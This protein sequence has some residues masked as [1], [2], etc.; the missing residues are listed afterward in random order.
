MKKVSIVKVVRLNSG[1][2]RSGGHHRPMTSNRRRRH[3]PLRR[4][5]GDVTKLYAQPYADAHGFYCSS[6]EEF[7]AG[8]AKL[9]RRHVEEV[10]IQFID[11]PDSLAQLFGALDIGQADVHK[12]FDEIEHYDLET[13]AKLYGLVQYHGG[14]SYL[15]SAD[16]DDIRMFEGRPEDWAYSLI[17]DTGFPRERVGGTSWSPKLAPMWSY[18]DFDQ[19]WRGL[20]TEL[21]EQTI[22]EVDHLHDAQEKVEYLWNEGLISEPSSDEELLPYFDAELFARD[23]ELEG[24][25]DSFQFGGDHWVMEGHN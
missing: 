11:G 25:I 9:A 7:D 14:K 15:E 1:L 8:M 19:Y 13:Q 3:S 23:A 20:E 21:D 22:E 16:L 24:S 4:N 6:S 2:H 5:H 10:E 17:E 12:W 18:F